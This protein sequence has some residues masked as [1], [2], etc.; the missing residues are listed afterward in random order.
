MT[1][2]F[3][4]HA[5]DLKGTG[6]L[7][8]VAQVAHRYRAG[9]EPE[10]MEYMVADFRALRTELRRRAKVIREPGREALPREQGDAR[11][12]QRP[13]PRPAPDRR[14]RGR[15]PDRCSS[16]RNYGKELEAIAPTS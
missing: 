15:V 1:C 14:R 12:G 9:D 5:Y 6:D 2:A 16:T 10:D 11:A 7:K 8:P 13:A 3:E 4:I